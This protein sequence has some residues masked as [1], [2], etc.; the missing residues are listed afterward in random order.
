MSLRRAAL[1]IIAAGD[2]N[3]VLRIFEMRKDYAA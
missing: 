2:A 3:G 1:S